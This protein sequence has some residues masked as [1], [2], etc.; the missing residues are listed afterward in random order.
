M[1]LLPHFF[2]AL[3]QSN[4]P[5]SCCFAWPPPNKIKRRS[6][7][8]ALTDVPHPAVGVRLIY[9]V[10]Q[11]DKLARGQRPSPLGTRPG[12]PQH[13]PRPN[14]LPE[15]PEILSPI[16][17]SNEWFEVRQYLACFL[18]IHW[19]TM[20]IV[21]YTFHPDHSDDEDR[22]VR[23]GLSS[24][25]RTLLVVFCER[26]DGHTIRIVSARKATA[27]EREQYEQGI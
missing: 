12:R 10:Y 20:G 5:G 7:N 1:N 23:F 17:L 22:Y 9:Q 14:P 11:D 25:H 15:A 8:P 13:S 27:R 4:E 16:F 26:E 24:L 6:T 21:K 3:M 19:N 18:Y 2:R